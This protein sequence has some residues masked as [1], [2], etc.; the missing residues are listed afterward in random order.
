MLMVF[1]EYF[2]ADRV[3]SFTHGGLRCDNFLG[4]QQRSY[5][6][7]GW[8]QAQFAQCNLQNNVRGR[9]V[10]SRQHHSPLLLLDCRP[11]SAMVV[12]HP[13]PPLASASAFTTS[14]PRTP[15]CH[16]LHSSPEKMPGSTKPSPVA[17]ICFSPWDWKAKRSPGAIPPRTVGRCTFV[18]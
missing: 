14:T 7:S 1:T 9:S 17:A 4:I 6:L 16:L 2:F 8:H 5:R 10:S 11:N 12:L 15:A 18:A 13:S 3:I